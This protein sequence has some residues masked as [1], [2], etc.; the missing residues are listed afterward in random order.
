MYI[1]I[2]FIGVSIKFD[3]AGSKVKHSK[4]VRG[5]YSVNIDHAFYS[6]TMNLYKGLLVY[7]ILYKP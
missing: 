6:K 2:D 5:F 7:C 4:K 3:N 1:L